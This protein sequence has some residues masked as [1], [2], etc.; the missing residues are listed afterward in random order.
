[1]RATVPEKVRPGTREREIRPGAGDDAADVLLG[2]CDDQAQ[3]R[4][5]L[6]HQQD[7]IGAGTDQRA[8]DGPGDR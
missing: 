1:M 4:D 7:G 5:L 8:R 6:N 2:H 3:M